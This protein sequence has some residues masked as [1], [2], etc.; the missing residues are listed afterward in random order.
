MC[1]VG[2]CCESE[3]P[4][5]FSI[6]GLVKRLEEE[7]KFNSYMASDKLSKELERIRS[8]VHYLQKVASEPA[9][10]H[11]ELDELEEKVTLQYMFYLGLSSNLSTT[12]TAFQNLLIFLFTSNVVVQVAH[13]CFM[14]CT[15]VELSI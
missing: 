15:L 10:G 6:A 8:K 12:P 5:G 14:N 7:I 3:V 9:M 4:K 2:V 13:I 11:A 1:H